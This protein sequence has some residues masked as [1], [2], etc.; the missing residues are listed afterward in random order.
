[1]NKYFRFL[2]LYSLLSN[3]SILSNI[4]YKVSNYA[5]YTVVEW[6]VCTCVNN[7][8]DSVL[9]MWQSRV[10]NEQYSVAYFDRITALKTRYL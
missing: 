6:M 4:M 1:M 5:N 9:Y 7:T 10:E 8:L 2:T 3:Y